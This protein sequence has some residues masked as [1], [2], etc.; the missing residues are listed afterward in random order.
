MA[1]RDRSDYVFEGNSINDPVQ[2]VHNGKSV[3]YLRGATNPFARKVDH[4]GNE[5]SAEDRNRLRNVTG[6]KIQDPQ[7]QKQVLEQVKRNSRILVEGVLGMK[8]TPMEVYVGGKKKTI[9]Y[10]NDAGEEITVER[11]EPI[12]YAN[13]VIVINQQAK[14]SGSESSV[15]A[16]AEMEEAEGPVLFKPVN[17]EEEYEAQEAH[18]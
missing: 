15:D 9:R 8:H 13:N 14:T 16:D 18:A 10:K 11:V 17:E 6:I 7:L 2:K 1:R 4:E 3:V 12:L 5:I